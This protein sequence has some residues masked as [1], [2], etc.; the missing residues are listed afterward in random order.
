MKVIVYGSAK[1]AEGKK[2]R[3]SSGKNI[4]ELADLV[5]DTCRADTGC[6]CS[7]KKSF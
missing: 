5:V 7:F 2:S 3:H 4:F 1:E 6:L